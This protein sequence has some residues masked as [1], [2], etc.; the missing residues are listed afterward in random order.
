VKPATSA[1]SLAIGNPADGLYALDTVRTTGGGLAAVTD[2]EAVEG[3]GLLART[4]G[5]FTEMAGGVTVASLARLAAD[6]VVSPQER[7]VLYVSGHGLKTVEK[8][9]SWSGADAHSPIAPT[10]EAFS[11]LLDRQPASAELARQPAL[12][13]AGS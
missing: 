7:V 8:L 4:E 10:L 1:T 2:E 12:A 13:G 6:G 3:I 9:S 11:E 5:I